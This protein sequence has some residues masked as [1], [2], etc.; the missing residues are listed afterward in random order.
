MGQPTVA[1]AF[2]DKNLE[3]S[4][5]QRREKKGNDAYRSMLRS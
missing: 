4:V 2:S 1:A 3:D 5:V